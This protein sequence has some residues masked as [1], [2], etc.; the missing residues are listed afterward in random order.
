MLGQ[1]FQRFVQ[2]SPLSV[3]VRGT[4]DAMRGRQWTLG[5]GRLLARAF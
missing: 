3:M 5:A 1:V 4:L 2:H